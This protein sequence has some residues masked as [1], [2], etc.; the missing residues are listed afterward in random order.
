MIAYCSKRRKLTFQGLSVGIDHRIGNL[1]ILHALVSYCD[2]IKSIGDNTFAAS[3]KLQF[4]ELPASV[5][6]IDGFP[7]TGEVTIITPKGSYAEQFALDSGILKVQN[8]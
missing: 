2:K 5:D 8:N 7:F 6:K 1:V 3:D 4:V